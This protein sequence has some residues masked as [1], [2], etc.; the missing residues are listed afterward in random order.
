MSK[1]SLIQIRNDAHFGHMCLGMYI[2][3]FYLFYWNLRYISRISQKCDNKNPPLMRIFL[4]KDA[5]ELGPYSGW[6]QTVY[7]PGSKKEEALELDVYNQGMS[8][9][10]LCNKWQQTGD[11]PYRE[12]CQFAHGIKELRPV[13]RHPRYKTEVCRMVLAGDACP[14]GHRCHF[15]HALTEEERLM[16]RWSVSMHT[17]Y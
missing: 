13:M 12:N 6:Q 16:P 8:K 9:T 2:I 4:W 11:C 17:C 14:Y 5:Y 7:V 1:S 15:R 10:E 3:L